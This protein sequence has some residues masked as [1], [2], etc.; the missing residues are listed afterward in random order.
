MQPS[1]LNSTKKLLG[2][3]ENYTAFDIDVM[4]HINA[5]FSV[6]QQL[7]VGPVNGYMIEDAN[8]VWTDFDAPEVLIKMIRSYIFLKVK[9]AFDPSPTSFHL[10][11][12]NNQISELEWRMNVYREEVNYVPLVA[13]VVE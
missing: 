5:T 11:S 13:A 8:D 12:M 7:G 10:E 4:T 9:M 1:I 3:D 2:I 6:L